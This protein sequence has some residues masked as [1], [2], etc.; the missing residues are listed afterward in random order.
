MNFVESRWFFPVY[1]AIIQSTEGQAA[2]N[3]WSKVE[4]I[5]VDS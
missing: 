4:L 1:A 3:M 5:Q 2:V